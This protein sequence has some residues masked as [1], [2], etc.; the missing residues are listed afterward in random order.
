M[1]ALHTRLL[2]VARWPGD[3]FDGPQP[4]I[5]SAGSVYFPNAA[6]FH[7]RDWTSKDGFIYGTHGT[8]TTFELEARIAMLE[9]AAHGLLFPS[10]L[11]AIAALYMAI[12]APGDELVVPLNVYSANREFITNTLC[13]WGIQVC[14][15]DPT[16]LSTLSFGPAS[17]LVWI[18]APGTTTFEFPDIQEIASR[19]RASDVAVALDSTWS[20]GIAFRPFD[21]PIDYSVHSLSKFASGSGD[22]LMGS[23]TCVDKARF[24]VVRV[25]AAR[26]GLYVSPASAASVGK[27]LDT[28]PMRYRAQD[29][30]TRRILDELASDRRISRLFHPSRVDNPGHQT[31]KTQCCAAAGLFS[32]EFDER[33]TQQDIDAFAD[34]LSLFRIGFG[35]GGPRSLVLPCGSSIVSPQQTSGQVVRVSVGLEDP[36]D[37][38]ADL[39]Q[40]LD[41][42]EAGHHGN[43]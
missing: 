11:S 19:A 2:D 24:D 8:P 9:G 34:S 39:R 10:G 6:A 42:L 7:G 17:R 15:Y 16:D 13:R 38:L 26:Q 30:S 18:E 35:W 33:Y 40:S 4:A 22:T 1:P 5:H 28:L 37:L 31:W 29:V 36:T 20:A 12:L 25:A 43:G 27:G 14:L 32:I 21:F 3:K 41:R 23:V